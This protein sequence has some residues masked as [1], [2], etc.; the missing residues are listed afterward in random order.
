MR[1]K[2]LNIGQSKSGKTGALASLLL[3]GYNIYMLD[4]DNNSEVLDTLLRDNPEALSRLHRVT[5]RDAIIPIRGVPKVK[6]PPTAYKGAGKALE[7]WQADTLDEDSILVID[8]LTSMS[9]AA[10][11]EAL[12]MSGRLNQ[13]PQLQDYGWLADS[14]MLFMDMLTG[15]AFHCHI[16]V[17]TH[18]KWFAA[19][20]DLQVQARGLPNARGQQ[21]ASTVSR[22][23]S[24]VLLTRTIGSGPATKRVISTQPQGVVEVAAPPIAS[25]KASYPVEGGLAPLFEDILGH[26]CIPSTAQTKTET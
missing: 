6:S 16:I 2:A 8:T 11:N 17:N 1:I 10:F 12:M 5:L 26:G 22:Y 9:D 15:D 23:F 3:V 7:E 19:D 25:V 20:E 13:R 18:V 14:V 21:I 4:F 24:S